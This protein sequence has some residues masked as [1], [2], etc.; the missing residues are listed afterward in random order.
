MELRHFRRIDEGKTE[1]HTP[2]PGL[3]E[4]IPNVRQ[5]AIA[6]AI[7]IEDLEDRGFE[8]ILKNRRFELFRNYDH[9]AHVP[10]D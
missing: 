1:R 8:A 7:A 5:E 9:A 10:M 2:D 6:I 3:T 4:R